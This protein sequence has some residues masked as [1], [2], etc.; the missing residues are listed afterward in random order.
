M[1]IAQWNYL[2]PKSVPHE[3]RDLRKASFDYHLELGMPIIHKHKW[4]AADVRDGKVKV[5]PFH[6]DLYGRSLVQCNY[7]FGTG[8]IGGWDDGAITFVTF[9]D[10]QE[11]QIKLTPEG[12][13]YFDSHPQF[14][15]PWVPTLGDGDIIITADFELDTW[16]VIEEQERYV[17][18]EV[19][20]RTMRGFQSRVQTREYKV[21]QEGQLDKLALD[22]YRYRVPIVFDLTTVPMPLPT[23]AAPPTSSREQQVRVTGKNPTPPISTREQVVRVT[24]K[25]PDGGTSIIFGNY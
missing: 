25:D 6:D 5:C 17:L 24:G 18:R 8:Y 14:T 9:S 12:L 15:S 22:D 4:T 7:C 19:T 11:D 21:H 1:K 2:G 16:T 23:P 3:V 10:A 20:P 13:L